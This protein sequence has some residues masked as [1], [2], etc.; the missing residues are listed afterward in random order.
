M[1]LKD[2]GTFFDPDLHLP[3]NGK[4]YRIPAPDGVEGPRIRDLMLDKGLPT[5]EQ[6]E[7][8]IKVLGPAF[9]EMVADT[10]PWTMILHSGRTALIH[11]GFSPDMGEIHWTLAQLGR[12]VD[13]DNLADTLAAAR[14]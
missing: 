12:M 3:I 14:T 1:T 2:L 11:F 9:Q 10:V 5:V 8:A 4:R 6:T 7:E 13:L